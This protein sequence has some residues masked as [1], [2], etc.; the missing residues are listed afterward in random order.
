[1]DMGAYG[2]LGKMRQRCVSFDGPR[3]GSGGRR[4][5]LRSFSSVPLECMAQWVDQP[6]CRAKRCMLVAQT[7]STRRTESSCAMQ[8]T[9]QDPLK[10]SDAHLLKYQPQRAPT[11]STINRKF[12]S[13][14]QIHPSLLG[15]EVEASS[16]M[17]TVSQPSGGK[18]YCSLPFP[19]SYMQEEHNPEKKDSKV[20]SDPSLHTFRVSVFQARVGGWK[21][22][23]KLNL[24]SN[25][26]YES[27]MS[28]KERK[29]QFG[30]AVLKKPLDQEKTVSS[31]SSTELRAA[32]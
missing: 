17:K 8:R 23:L 5:G 19:H 29:G 15:Q 22:R 31:L 10:D 1:M 7:E 12:Y 3:E 4:L 13:Q 16:R 28:S 25:L 6:S 2:P 32:L 26:E 9:M 24:R 14:G 21:M 27:K 30:A 11:A 20:N 18:D